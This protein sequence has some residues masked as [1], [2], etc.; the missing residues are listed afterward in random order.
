MRLMMAFCDRVDCT[1]RSNADINYLCLSM[2]VFR[3]YSSLEIIMPFTFTPNAWLN[4]VKPSWMAISLR[5][6]Y[7]VGV[8]SLKVR[9]KSRSA[10]Y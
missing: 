10:N 5:I 4:R 2:Q 1:S 8:E 9:I 6:Y 3:L 7:S